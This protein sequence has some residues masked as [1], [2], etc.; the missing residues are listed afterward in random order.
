[1]L[2]AYGDILILQPFYAALLAVDIFFVIAGFLMSFRFFELQKK[3]KTVNLVTFTLR[4]VLMRYMR[5][6]PAFALVS[7]NSRLSIVEFRDEQINKLYYLQI[8]LIAIV[9]AM[10]IN[11]TSQFFMIEDVEGNCKRFWW[12]NLLM[13]QNLFPRDELCMTW[14]W[15]VAADF[16]LFIA[17]S[18][19][20]AVSVK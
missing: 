11:D 10:F 4:K 8:L 15:Y 9:V 7:G 12:R 13:I 16:Q 2:F 18:I 5:L 14:S 1:M 6:A 3:Q 17:A 19:L 20:L